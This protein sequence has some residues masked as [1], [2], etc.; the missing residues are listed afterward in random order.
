[1]T[2]IYY[3]AVFD[4]YTS[5]NGKKYQQM[6]YNS[7]LLGLEFKGK[8]VVLFCQSQEMTFDNFTNL[9]P[10]GNHKSG[11]LLWFLQPT[12]MVSGLFKNQICVGHRPQ[13]LDRDS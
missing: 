7:K 2:G 1:M 8:W 4:G 3:T 5:L 13:H 6:R 9:N 10:T 11:Q 12:F